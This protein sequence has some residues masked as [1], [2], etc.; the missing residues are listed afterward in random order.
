[1]HGGFT[2]QVYSYSNAAGHAIVPYI[3]GDHSL[4][5]GPYTSWDSIAEH[6]DLFVSF[7]G[8]GLKN[9]QVEPGGMGEHAT[10][11]WLERLKDTKI[12]FVSITPLKDDTADFLDA[13]WIQPRPN[14]DVAMMLGIAHTLVEEG[15]HDEAYLAR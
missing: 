11:K 2:A 14:T 10:H 8:I 6:T 7:G 5:R 9:T 12:E 1:M 4:S 3:F 13:E 15:L